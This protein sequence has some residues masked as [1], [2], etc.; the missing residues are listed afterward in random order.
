MS[1]YKCIDCNQPVWRKE[2]K[3]CRK[4]FGKHN[5]GKN[6]PNYIDGRAISNNCQQC[7]EKIKNKYAFLCGDCYIKTMKK[8][9]HPNYK[10]GETL[11]KHYCI[12]CK[13]EINYYTFM[14]GQKRCRKCANRLKT[15]FGNKNPAWKGGI[16]ELH[17]WIRSLNEMDKWRNEVFKRDNYICRKCGNKGYIEAH[18]KIHFAELLNKFLKEYDQFS[19]IEDKETLV[20]LAV[21]WQAFWDIDNGETR[22]KGCHIHKKKIKIQKKLK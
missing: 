4:C 1:K 2:T 17:F 18:H 11:K 6:N 16:T 7:N 13:K 14:Y 20:R 19:P 15:G 9:R 22:C 3:R 10:H 5:Q 8:E 12:D 21:K